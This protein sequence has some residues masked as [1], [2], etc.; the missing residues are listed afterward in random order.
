VVGLSVKDLWALRQLDTEA[1]SGVLSGTFELGGSARAPIIELDI[2]VQGAVFNEFRMPQTQGSL[3]YRD[4]RLDG[5][6]TFHRSGEQVLD[7]ELDL[8]IDLALRDVASRQLPGQLSVRARADR[9]DLTLINAINPQIRSASGE[10]SADFG[11]AGTWE[12]PELAGFVEITNGAATFPSLGVRHEQMNGRVS[13]SGDTIYVDRFGVMGDGGSAELDGFVWLEGL[14]RPELD[15]AIRAQE[16]RAIAV[17]DF[18]TLTTSG[19]ISLRGPVFG[20]TLTGQGTV[21]QGVVYF[22]DIIEK[23]IISLEEEELDPETV[24]LIRRQGLGREFEN[25]FLDSLRIENLSLGMG[26]DVRLRSTEANIQLTGQ[27]TV[28]KAGEQ[29]RIDGTLQTPRGTYSLPLGPALTKDFAVTRGEVRYF[30]TPDLNAAL[31]I[32]ARHQLRSLRGDPVAV[33]VNV[34]GTINEPQLTLTSDVRPPLA[35]TE[36]ISYLIFGAPSAQAAGQVG[37]LGESAVATIAGRLG[38]RLGT[39][40]ISDLGIPLDFFEVRPEFGSGLG[41]EIALGRQIGERWF[42]TVSPRICRHQTFTVENLGASVEFRMNREWR[43]SAS[44]DP[45]RTCLITGAQGSELR[46]QLGVDLLWEKSY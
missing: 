33:F 20:A 22:A 36:I 35:D 10:L 27:L 39:A 1:T 15:L 14:T 21:T 3:S 25:R 46:Y 30:G 5:T 28:S 13:L 4:R 23:E 42:L 7:V 9:M 19:E 37:Y 8:P 24:A 40:L 16:F 44:A 31:D 6:F 17:P 18:L 26:A 11:I 41:T 38:G 29:Y 45:L 2:G 32:D 12:V 34:G 43:L